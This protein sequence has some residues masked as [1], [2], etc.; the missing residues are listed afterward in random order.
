MAKKRFRDYTHA[1]KLEMA[2]KVN[3]YRDEHPRET[4]Q[5]ALQATGVDMREGAYWTYRHQLLAKNGQ[6]QEVEDRGV[7]FPLA[8]IPERK[9]GRPPASKTVTKPRAVDEDKTL[10]A[11]LLE[12][13]AALLRR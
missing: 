6:Q 9:V 4:V 7:E 13:A 10:A 11:Q 1:E 3:D 5:E 2:R 12:V 8:L